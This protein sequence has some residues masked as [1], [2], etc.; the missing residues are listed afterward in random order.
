MHV[1]KR[2]ASEA[3]LPISISRPAKRSMY[4]QTFPSCRNTYGV[5]IDDVPEGQSLL[6][7]WIS[8][9]GET[10]RVLWQRSADLAGMFRLSWTG[11]ILT[12]PTSGRIV[13]VEEIPEANIPLPET[14]P[15]YPQKSSHSRPPIPNF[16]MI[17]PQLGIP[18]PMPVDP[19]YAASSPPL[20]LNA[21][22][23]TAGVE[24]QLRMKYPKH[25]H[26]HI[27]QVFSF[28]L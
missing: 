21:P 5:I 28:P 10:I 22:L 2:S 8:L 20:P 25:K 16:N 9:F 26:V 6:N 12:P 7:R 17:P 19:T 15:P 24:E 27:S 11:L 23:S 3:E 1:I 4:T 14:P 18:D 13:P